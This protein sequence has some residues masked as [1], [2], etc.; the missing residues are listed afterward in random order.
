MK[1]NELKTIFFEIGVEDSLQDM[2]KIVDATV[3]IKEQLRREFK[4][5]DFTISMK[6]DED[7][8]YLGCSVIGSRL[9]SKGEYSRRLKQNGIVLKGTQA[10]V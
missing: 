2:D 3:V 9:E 8:F 4:C 10:R 1:K 6:K 5:K 7:G